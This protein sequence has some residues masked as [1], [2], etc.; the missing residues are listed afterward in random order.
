MFGI[1]RDGALDLVVNWTP[2]AIMIVFA[3]PILLIGAFPASTA[4]V[5]VSMGLIVVPVAAL[6]VVSVFA[7][8]FVG[9]P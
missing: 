9:P 6:T 1:D 2:V 4:A 7:A 3:V 8:P 5:V